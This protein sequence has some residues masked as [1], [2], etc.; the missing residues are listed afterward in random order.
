MEILGK[1][2]KVF[3]SRSV[4]NLNERQYKLGFDKFLV[5]DTFCSYSRSKQVCCMTLGTLSALFLAKQ[6]K[7][8]V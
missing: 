6:L 5:L 4:K 1:V 8:C 3:Q 7:V 2:L